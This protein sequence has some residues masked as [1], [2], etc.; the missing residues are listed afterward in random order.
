MISDVYHTGWLNNGASL[1][2]NFVKCTIYMFEYNGGFK[3]DPNPPYICILHATIYQ[4][5]GIVEM[6]LAYQKLRKL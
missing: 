2:S 1:G 3:E 4:V 6:R 5:F